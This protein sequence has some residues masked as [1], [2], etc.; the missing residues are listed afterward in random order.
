MNQQ[1]EQNLKKLFIGHDEAY[2]FLLLYCQYSGLIDDLVDEEKDI[3]RVRQTSWYAGLVFN[4]NYWKKFGH[5][6]YIVDRLCHNNYFDSVIM[7]QSDVEWKRQHALIYSHTGMQMTL[8]VILL[9]FG[10]GTMEQ[11]SML[12]REAAYNREQ[13]PTGT[14]CETVKFQEK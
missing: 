9:E 12:I 10:Q 8:A 13:E 6:L 5:I 4:C 1:L 2:E 11:W 14:I 7:E 3:Q